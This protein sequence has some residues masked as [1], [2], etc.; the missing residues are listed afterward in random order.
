MPKVP[1]VMARDYDPADMADWYCEPCQ[2]VNSFIRRKCRFC[3][4]PRESVSGKTARETAIEKIA[5]K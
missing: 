3:K 5:A 2:A 1:R 4:Q